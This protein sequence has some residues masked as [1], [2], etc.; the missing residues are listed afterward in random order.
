[1]LERHHL[2]E[3]MIRHD[4]VSNIALTGFKENLRLSSRTIECCN[5]TL[6]RLDRQPDARGD[7]KWHHIIVDD[8]LDDAGGFRFG[9]S[10]FQKGQS[11]NYM[12]LTNYLLGFSAT[13]HI[14]PRSLATFFQTNIVSVPINA[15]RQ[16]GG[17]H[18]RAFSDKLWGLEDSHLGALLLAIGIRFV[19]CPSAT[20]FKIEHEESP[21]QRRFDLRR[22]RQLFD[23]LLN[24]RIRHRAHEAHE[25][26]VHL[27]AS[28]RLSELEPLST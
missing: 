27:R 17:F 13:E 8:D 21:E 22:H 11:I 16:V 12:S 15:V 23:E 18:S 9:S 26:I 7:W 4:R 19:P 25:E 10:L 20:A 6:A 2:A 24:E 1:V 28:G 5:E 14:G 3:H